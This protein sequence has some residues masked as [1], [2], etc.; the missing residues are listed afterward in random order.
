MILSV[1]YL[2]PFP[3]LTRT[4]IDLNR[5]TELNGR[6][7]CRALMFVLQECSRYRSVPFHALRIWFELG[8]AGLTV[9]ACFHGLVP[10]CSDRQHWTIGRADVQ[11]VSGTAGSDSSHCMVL[12]AGFAILLRS[13][14]G[15]APIPG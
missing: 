7:G 12:L 5:E 11:V 13:G 4:I 2:K 15:R 3:N 6:Y 14:S 8:H 10:E 9:G 1:S